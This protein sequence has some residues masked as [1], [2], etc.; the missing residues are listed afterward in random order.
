MTMTFGKCNDA[1]A[2]VGTRD[3]F[4]VAAILVT[5]NNSLNPGEHV[6]FT[7]DTYTMVERVT[8]HNKAHAIVDPWLEGP[9]RPGKKFLVVLMPDSSTNLR[10]HFDLKYTDV[11]KAYVPLV[12]DTWYDD[13]DDDGCRGCYN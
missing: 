7:D 13:N 5:S 11:P 10:H 8:G 2:L 12:D 9:P 1:D 4:H 6:R 3:A